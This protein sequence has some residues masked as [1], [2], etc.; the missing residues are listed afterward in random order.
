MNVE[1]LQELLGA[2]DTGTLVLEE[3]QQVSILADEIVGLS[4]FCRG[5]KLVVFDITRRL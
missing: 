2:N 1:Y 3:I 5:E 4:S